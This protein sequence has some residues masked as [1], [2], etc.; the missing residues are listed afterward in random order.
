[1]KIFLP[2]DPLER[3]VFYDGLIRFCSVSVQSSLNFSENPTKVQFVI[4]V[5][6]PIVVTYNYILFLSFFKKAQEENHH[7]I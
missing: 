4:V 1:M 7:F 3:N 2:S 5:S 6:R